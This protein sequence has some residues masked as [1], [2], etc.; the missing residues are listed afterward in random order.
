M[1][2]KIFYPNKELSKFIRFFW[3]LESNDE[4]YIHRSYADTCC[5][6]IFI[7]KGE[8]TAKDKT[9]K[10]FK[11][12][13]TALHAQTKNYSLFYA[14]KGLNIF[15]VYF[16]PYAIMPLI[17]DKTS[18]VTNSFIDIQDLLKDDYYKIQEAIMSEKYV[19]KKIDIVSKFYTQKLILFKDHYITQA[20]KAVIDGKFNN[21]SSLAT[22]YNMSERNFNRKFIEYSGFNPQTAIRISRFQNTINKFTH[23]KLKLTDIGLKAGYYDQSHFIHDF[24]TFSGYK[25]SDFF[26]ALPEDAKWLE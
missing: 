13:Q 8:I 23:S 24:K 21:V 6:M 22:D 3:T 1:S 15:G 26:N 16:Y 5:E 25:P 17:Q 10:E 9:G 19:D 4:T 2:Y 14:K 11:H 7:D 12:F 18:I 20:V